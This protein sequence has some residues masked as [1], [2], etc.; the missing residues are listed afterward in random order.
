MLTNSPPSSLRCEHCGQAPDRA[1]VT[2]ETHERDGVA[3]WT[4]W[5]QVCYT[6]WTEERPRHPLYG[7]VISFHVEEKPYYAELPAIGCR[8]RKLRDERRL[9]Q[10]EAASRC[11]VKQAAWSKWETGKQLA[12]DEQ[13][14]AVVDAF[15]VDWPA[16]FAP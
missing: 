3:S 10:A 1:V 6:A 4:F 9:T 16:I 2:V 13:Q 12:L 5:G 11:G 8:L 7:A 15:G 14:Q